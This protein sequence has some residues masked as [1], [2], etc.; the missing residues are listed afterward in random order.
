MINKLKKY[1]IETNGDWIEKVKPFLDKPICEIREETWS[2]SRRYIN[3]LINCVLTEKLANNF[4]VNISIILTNLKYQFY[5][6]D[7]CKN[8]FPLSDKT[9]LILG[10]GNNEKKIFLS[11]DLNYKSVRLVALGICLG[12][13]LIN[14]AVNDDNPFFIGCLL[15]QDGKL[16][17][18]QDEINFLDELCYE[19]ALRLLIPEK[20]YHRLD[21]IG[22]TVEIKPEKNM[23]MFAKIFDVRNIDFDNRI[24]LEESKGALYE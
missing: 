1:Y 19:F 23:D 9:I 17:V 5:E 14:Q 20:I 15:N 8:N 3:G 10:E 16:S 18:H 4:P 13:Y 21:I 24:K 7:L 12:D 2:V 11:S 22:K 6:V